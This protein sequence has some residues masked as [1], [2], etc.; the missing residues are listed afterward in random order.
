MVAIV[1]AAS[2]ALACGQSACRD[3]SSEEP[4]LQRER[5]SYP[6]TIPRGAHYP[7]QGEIEVVGA[8]SRPL[9]RGSP[10]FTELVENRSPNVLFKDEEGTGADR[11]MTAALR[12][13]LE[14]LSEL[15]GK[16]WP[17]LKL[18]VT[19]AWD[20]DREH[21]ANSL[22]YEGRAAD[23]TTSDRELDKLPRLG[24]LALQAGFP[25]VSHEETHIHA[26]VPASQAHDSSRR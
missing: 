11:L 12:A 14:R 8:I 20:E 4:P 5:L 21:G 13:H 7:E 16:E 26:S 23:F 6:R 1:F 25:W 3:P 22:H 24:G 9:T 10:G 17:G 2:C 15:V 19:E 18:R